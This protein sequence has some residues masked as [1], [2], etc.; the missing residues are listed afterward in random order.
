MVSLKKVMEQKEVLLLVGVLALVV[1][2]QQ[3]ESTGFMSY[4]GNPEIKRGDKGDPRTFLTSPGGDYNPGVRINLREKKKDNWVM[5][6][7]G[8]LY[9]ACENDAECLRPRCPTRSSAVC[10]TKLHLCKPTRP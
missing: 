9:C 1:A 8:Y 4:G 7:K 3:W 10:D 2:L 6:S 5:L